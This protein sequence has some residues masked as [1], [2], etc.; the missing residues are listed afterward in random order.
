MAEYGSTNR[1]IWLKFDTFVG[2]CYQIQNKITLD[3][4]GNF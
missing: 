4:K 2:R 3:F 1:D